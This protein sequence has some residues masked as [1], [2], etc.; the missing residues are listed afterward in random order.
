V[1]SIGFKLFNSEKERLGLHE[2]TRCFYYISRTVDTKSLYYILT[3]FSAS[4][5]FSVILIYQKKYLTKLTMWFKKL[6]H[7]VLVFFLWSVYSGKAFLTLFV[8]VSWIPILM[9]NKC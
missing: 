7:W 8:S 5:L 4:T 6:N 3:F 1:K 9:F 2:W